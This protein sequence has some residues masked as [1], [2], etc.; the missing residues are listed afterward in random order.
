MNHV[1]EYFIYHYLLILIKHKI[2]YEI[3]VEATSLPYFPFQILISE[4]PIF[5]Q[6]HSVWHFLLTNYTCV[7]FN[8]YLI[9]EN[10]KKSND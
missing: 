1:D 4:A 3:S 6:S 9:I 10:K 7:Q 8:S 5:F 2:I